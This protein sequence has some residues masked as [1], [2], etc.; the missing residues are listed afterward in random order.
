MPEFKLTSSL[1]SSVLYWDQWTMAVGDAGASSTSHCL[2]KL[3]STGL[4]AR[5]WLGDHSG[6]DSA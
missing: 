6:G 1:Y 3:K 5:S 4:A 2:S